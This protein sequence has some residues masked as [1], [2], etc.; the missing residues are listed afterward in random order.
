MRIL[1]I[2][3]TYAP[4]GIHQDF[5][6]PPSQIMISNSTLEGEQLAKDIDPDVIIL[7]LA[8][9]RDNGINTCKAIRKFC[10][11]PIL[12]LS[13]YNNPGMIAAALDSG[14][15]QYLIKPVSK[16]V[17]LAHISRYLHPVPITSIS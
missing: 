7:D 2:N 11:A 14:A 17:L 15:D 10:N 4:N 9:S 5:L 1:F 13:A 12:L 3:D 8:N 16:N 6:L